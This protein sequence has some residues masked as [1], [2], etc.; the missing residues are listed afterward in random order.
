MF[1]PS[2][3]YAADEGKII[4]ANRASGTISIIDSKTDTLIK[5]VAL[6]SAVNTPQPMYVV[7]SPDSDR[8]F[9]GDRAND[10]VVIFNDSTFKYETSVATG[11]GVFH[12]WADVGDKQLWVNN[13]IDKTTTVIDPITLE[14]LATVA[15]PID[16]VNLGGKPH[17]VILDPSGEFAY[18]TMLGVTGPYDVVVKFS[19]HNFQEV[20][21]TDVGKDPHLSVTRENKLLYV[22]TQNSNAVYILAR[23]DLSLVELLFVPGSHGAAI[24]RNGKTFYTTNISGGGVQGLYSIDTASNVLLDDG[25]NTNF[26]IPHN[27]VLNKSGSKLYISHSG[28]NANKITVYNINPKT[29]LPTFKS[30]IIV[31]NNPFGLTAIK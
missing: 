8:I 12:M 30:S 15:M 27:I 6:P 20:L 18:I 21:R 26:P 24:P 9:V 31:G 5:T 13:D 28:K 10:R 11:K 14:V 1:S 23:N 16:I 25:V 17:D 29:R 4:V 19:T 22:P 3:I 2:L 7:H